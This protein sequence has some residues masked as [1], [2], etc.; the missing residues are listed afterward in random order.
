MRHTVDLAAGELRLAAMSG[1]SMLLMLVMTA[2]S[3]LIAW[4]LIV[5]LALDVL[6]A[7]GVPWP[8]SGMSLTVLHVLLAYLLWRGMLKLSRNLTLPELRQA[9]RKPERP[10]A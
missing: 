10:P 5:A 1:V 8:Y 6:A 4:G 7:I 2:A 9:L 3:L